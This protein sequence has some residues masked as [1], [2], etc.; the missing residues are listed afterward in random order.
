[1]HFNYTI[2]RQNFNI[3]ELYSA[4]LPNPSAVYYAVFYH[5]PHNAKNP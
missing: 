5:S 3:P 1:M 4:F 2:Y